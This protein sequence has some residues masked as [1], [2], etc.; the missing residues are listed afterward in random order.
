MSSSTDTNATRCDNTPCNGGRAW[1]TDESEALDSTKKFCSADCADEWVANQGNTT[2]LTASELDRSSHAMNAALTLLK[3]MHQ[4]AEQMDRLSCYTDSDGT[5]K[6]P[7]WATTD[8]LRAQAFVTMMDNGTEAEKAECMEQAQLDKGLDDDE[9]CD[10][11]AEDDG[12]LHVVAV[13]DLDEGPKIAD[14]D[15]VSL[16]PSAMGELDEGKKKAM[17]LMLASGYGKPWCNQ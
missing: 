17:K 10:V 11:V 7:E 2:T 4:K 5:W 1:L 16:F 12:S 9:D 15:A 14:Y 13:S 8:E 3:Q 6:F